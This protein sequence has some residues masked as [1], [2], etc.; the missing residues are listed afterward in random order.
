MTWSET[1]ALASLLGTLLAA[2]PAVRAALYL[3]H[4]TNTRQGKPVRRASP[5]HALKAHLNTR[6]DVIAQKWPPWLFWPFLLGIALVLY[7]AG[8]HALLTF[9]VLS[10]AASSG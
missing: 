6:I 2:I 9:G 1:A 7:A 3:R 10:V 8:V 4:R 5:F